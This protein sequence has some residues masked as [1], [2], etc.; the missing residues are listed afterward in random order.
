[1]KIL[2]IPQGGEGGEQWHEERHGCVTGTKIENAIG[3]CFSNAKQQ[4]QMGGKTWEFEGSKLVCVTEGKQ[5]KASKDKQKTLLLELVSDRQSELEIDDYCSAE[6]ERGNELEPLSLK[7]ASIK[8]S[9]L[10]EPCGMLVSDTLPMFK[11]SPDAIVL[12]K[13]GVVVG[14]YETKSKAGKKHIEYTIANVVPSEHLMQCLT[15]MIMDDCVKYWIFGHFDDRN[16]V[17]NLFTTGIKRADYED[18]IQVARAVLNDFLN[19]VNET[20]EK[21]G[22]AYND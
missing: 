16:K 15:P 13:N 5:T 3:A 7:A 4:W 19:E 9:V 2:N 21:M 22:G 10:L 1:M 6:M 18:F 14:G 20:V 8:H 11:F 12:D 17:S